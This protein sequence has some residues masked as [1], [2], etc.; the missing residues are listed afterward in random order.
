M[1]SLCFQISDRILSGHELRDERL[2]PFAE[3]IK[4]FGT[5]CADVNQAFLLKLYLEC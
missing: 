3:L 2:E 4:H 1:T 5:A